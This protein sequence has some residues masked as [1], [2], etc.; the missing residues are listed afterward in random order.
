MP[1]R[2]LFTV[3]ALGLLVALT[4]C[5]RATEPDA[6]FPDAS[7]VADQPVGEPAYLETAEAFVSAIQAGEPQ[8][9]WEL[10]TE[11][12]QKRLP[13]EQFAVEMG[14]MSPSG[15]KLVS[16]V[17]TEQA[18]FVLMA[19]EGAETMPVAGQALL[20]R[21]VGEQWRVSFFV[22]Q[23]PGDVGTE[24]LVLQKTAEREFTLTWTGSGG[25]AQSLVMT[26][27]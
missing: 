27:F 9:A 5:P 15:H 6:M 19:L 3:S 4:G 22:P 20:L 26:E 24:G 2:H 17:A 8:Q 1:C 18:A 13:A 11:E 21:P 12:A 7:P 10:L 23:A 14:E 25:A 16:H